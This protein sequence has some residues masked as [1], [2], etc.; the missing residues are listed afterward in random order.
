M[1]LISLPN[2]KEEEKVIMNLKLTGEF[3]N[4]INN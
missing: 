1:N 2:K 4:G 3:F